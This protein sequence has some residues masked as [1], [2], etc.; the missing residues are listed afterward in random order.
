MRLQPHS[1]TA[2]S[3]RGFRPVHCKLVSLP[4]LYPSRSATGS[5]KCARLLTK[6]VKALRVLVVGDEKLVADIIVRIL[7][8]HDY[9]ATAVYSAEDAL[10]QCRDRYP[11]QSHECGRERSV[12]G[13]H[14]GG[15]NR[16]HGY[17]E[18]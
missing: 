9:D 2:S 4:A 12:V 7:R 16:S 10:D 6:I 5:R 17:D 1:H 18:S 15:I 3:L 14:G 13:C 8:L 11:L